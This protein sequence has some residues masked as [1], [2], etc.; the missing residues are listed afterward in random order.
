MQLSLSTEASIGE[1]M[2]ALGVPE[3][4]SLINETK[5]GPR[6]IFHLTRYGEIEP[7]WI[8]EGTF[9]P[10]DEGIELRS[11]SRTVIA[12]VE[13]TVPVLRLRIQSLDGDHL[14]TREA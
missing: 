10:R 3:A 5:R 6:Y 9:F 13:A 1:I 7:T 12:R 8:M 11:S 2:A 14:L 4:A